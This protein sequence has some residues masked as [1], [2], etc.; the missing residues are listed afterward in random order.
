MKEHWEEVVSLVT[1]TAIGGTLVGLFRG[2]IVRRYGGWLQW[3]SLLLGSTLVA[4]LTGLAIHDSGLSNSQQ[5]AMIGVCAFLAEDILL[6]LG[7]LATLF[8][9]DPLGTIREVWR[10]IRGK[11]DKS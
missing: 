8:R 9:N 11:G 6:G 4:T 2:I 1:A 10:A 7:T 3:T 5:A